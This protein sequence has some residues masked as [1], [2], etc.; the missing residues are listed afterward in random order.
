MALS[1]HKYWNQNDV[2]S[3]QK[4]LD[5][6]TQYNV[7]IWLGES[8]ENSNVWFKEAISLVESNNIG[9]AFWPM[10]KIENLA[11]VTSVTKTPEYDQLL[12]YW[13]MKALSLRL[14]LL[15]KH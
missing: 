9:W 8:G 2:A 6:R 12:K 15:K 1:F 13:I 7:P 14:I 11:G 10:K 4:M 3:I 5:Y